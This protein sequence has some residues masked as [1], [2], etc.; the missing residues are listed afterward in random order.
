MG[1]LAVTTLFLNACGG[2]QAFTKGEYDDPTRDALLNDQ[3]NEA[4][5][6]RLAKDMTKG[7]LECRS[8]KR[9]QRPVVIMERVQNRTEEHIDMKALTDKVRTSLTETGK[10]RFV[11]KEYREVL[12]EEYEY[13]ESGAVS[14]ATKLKRGRQVGA[15]YIITG[16]LMSNIQQVG[17]NKLIYYKLNMDLTNTETSIIDCSEEKEIRKKFKKRRISWL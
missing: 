17:D 1:L 11:N 16:R 6:Q 5:M 7:V 9:R 4:D 3:F 2:P 15:D 10:V 12:E 14:E 13:S 8:V